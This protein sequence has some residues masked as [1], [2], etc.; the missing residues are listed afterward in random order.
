MKIVV[1]PDKFKGS[2]SAAHACAAIIEGI[3]RV[4]KDA[5][6][7][8]IPMAD[9]GEGTVEALVAAT[10][11]QLRQ[12]KVCGPLGEE[13]E[14]TYGILGIQRGKESSSV[15]TAVLEMAAAAGLPLV[16]PERR[17][18]LQTTTFGVGQVIL[19]GLEVG[20]R[21]FVIGI[22]GSATNDC[23]CGMA[24]ALGVK[25]F[26]KSGKA[27]TT[28][29]TGARMGQAAG[30]DCGNIDPR[31]NECSF[32]V[33]CDVEN[34][35]LGPTGASY[36]YSPQKGAD[37][38]KVAILETNMTHI[39]GLIE[40]EVGKKVRDIPGAG[41]AGGLGAGMMAFLNGKLEKGIDIVMR[42]CRFAERIS[43]GQLI[44]TGE[45]RIDDSTVYGKT[46]AG[47]AREALK[48]SIPVIAL[49]GSVAG[50]VGRIHDI[51]VSAVLPICS[52]PMGLAEAMR[53]GSELLSRA[54]EQALRAALI[55][56]DK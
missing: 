42:C 25:F 21:D 48:Q 7:V 36:I 40:A 19:D 51:G 33:A 23:G 3:R 56:L 35:L 24:Q 11:G 44:I 53:N 45:G 13:V 43:G 50:E 52:G 55:Q 39:I 47:I 31:I 27:I 10:G 34:P 12:V 37:G 20:C 4:T 32:V 14:A 1:A 2:L 22:G 28:P 26:D 17:N 6:I 18:P 54:A 16:A 46:I 9:G 15:K 5:E 49:A 38:Q 41:A 30:L 8:G 29:M